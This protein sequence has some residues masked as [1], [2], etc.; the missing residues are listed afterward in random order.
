MLRRS[1]L[2]FFMGVSVAFMLAVVVVVTLMQH[3]CVSLPP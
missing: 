2:V 3:F 1:T